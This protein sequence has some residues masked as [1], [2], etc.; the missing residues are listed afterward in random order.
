[1]KKLLFLIGLSVAIHALGETTANKP[2]LCGP[3]QKIFSYLSGP[4]VKEQP[5]WIGKTE[6]NESRFALLINTKT[7]TWTLVEFNKDIACVLGAG[8]DYK[9]LFGLSI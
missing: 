4:D 6:S 9:N 1:M 8:V 7:Q 2:V 3:S 5:Y